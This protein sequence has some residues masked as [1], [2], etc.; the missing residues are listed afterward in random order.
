MY[1]TIIDLFSGAG[2]LTLGFVDNKFCGGFKS[3]LAIDYNEAAINTFNTN[4]DSHGI[5]GDITT[6]LADN[7]IPKTDV[8]IGGP[9]CQ[10]FSLLNKNRKNDKRRSLWQYYMAAVLRS[11]CK[12]FLIENVEGLLKSPE[13]YD[14]KNYANYIGYDVA[15]CV[16]NAAD[17]GVPQIRKRTFIIGSRI[18]NPNHFF[19]PPIT[20]SEEGLIRPKWRTVKD[21]ICDLPEPIGTKLNGSTPPLDLH[22]GRNPTSSRGK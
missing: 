22:F 4:F 16:L 7:E 13:Y 19:P 12:V 21:A 1:Y 20:H 14:I 10:G 5:T 9:P 18:G 17:Y 8:V 2:G 15:A 6:W 11:S 3:I